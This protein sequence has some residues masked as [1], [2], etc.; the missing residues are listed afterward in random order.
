MVGL[1]IRVVV[2]THL[3]SMSTRL[4]NLVKNVSLTSHKY[5]INGL[6]SHKRV[7]NKLVDYKRVINGSQTCHKQVDGS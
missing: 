2:S 6:M 5:V 1:P 4:V 3:V 7:T